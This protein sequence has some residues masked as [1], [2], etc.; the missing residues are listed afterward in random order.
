M[1]K[2]LSVLWILV[3]LLC[4]APTAPASEEASKPAPVEKGIPSGASAEWP[5]LDGAFS[6]TCGKDLAWTLADG[7]LTISGTG[8]MW[9]N[10]S[11]DGGGPWQ[12]VKDLI[13][14]VVIE[15]GVTRIGDNEF[16]YCDAI[17]SVTIPDTV[18]SI[19]NVPFDD[20]RALTVF[21]VSDDNPC[22]TAKDGVLFDIS[23]STLIACPAGR[24]E[25]AYEVP[26]SVTEIGKGA[27][28]Q[29]AGIRSVTLPEGLTSIGDHAFL[30]SG[31]TEITIP[32]SVTSIGR[33]A[34]D[35]C[36]SL[37]SVTIGNGVTSIGVG[38]FQYCTALQSVTI[39]EGVTA[40]APYTF[41]GC[42]RLTSITIPAGATSIGSCAFDRCASLKDVYYGGTEDEWSGIGIDE[43]NDPLLNASIHFG[44][45]EP[46]TKPSPAD[47]PQPFGE[48]LTWSISYDDV[49]TISGTG[50]MEDFSPGGMPWKGFQFEIE[51]IVIEPGV[52]SIGEN[53]FKDCGLL[54][55]ATIGDGVTKIG[56]EAFYSCSN[57]RTLT[58]PKSVT[59]IGE[60]AFYFCVSLT[61]VYYGGSES[62]WAKIEIGDSND[63]LLNATVHYR[64][65]RH[66]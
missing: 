60:K 23:L 54:M 64:S 47:A 53:A 35:E 5:V 16:L 37:R 50:D 65:A 40:I 21:Y 33:A 30:W 36:R 22:F 18:T 45:T 28:S 3:M 25:Q 9:D 13:R 61:D 4:L 31:L 20:C 66:Y 55:S 41:V 49:L 38:A 48:N 8:E 44:V 34:F 10:Y 26:D 6:G 43:G 52:T 27:F 62:D 14:N 32:D 59:S 1:K 24:Q 46:T 15:S 56:A 11:V 39:P 58:I 19:G 42:L 12:G 7:V 29:C 17:Q 63:P 2:L 51:E 57:L